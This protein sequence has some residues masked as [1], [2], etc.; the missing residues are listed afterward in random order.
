MV[1]IATLSDMVPL[2]GENRAL[3]HYGLAVL[4][5]S[6]RKGLVRLLSKLNI[7]QRYLS[8]DD[9][10]FM[11]T[12]RIN[13]M[14]RMGVP[15]DAFHMLSTEDENE[16]HSYVAHIEEI[17]NERKGMV[18]AL[19]KEVKKTIRER[20]GEQVPSVIVLGNPAWRPSLLGLAANSCAEEFD[21]PVFL[22]GRDGD[23]AIKGS[24]RSEGKTNVVNLMRAVPSGV[25]IHFGGH[26]H[27]GGFAVSNDA[28]HFLD[29]HLNEAKEMQNAKCKMQSDPA[30]SNLHGIN[31]SDEDESEKQMIDAELSL[32]MVDWR[33]QEELE[34]LAPFGTG[35]PKPVFLFRKV[36]PVSVRRFGKAKDHIEIMFKKANGNKLA[37]IAFF[38]AT[39]TWAEDLREGVSIDLVGSIEKSFF[40]GRRELR[41]RVVEVM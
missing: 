29:R 7:A 20:H 5:K 31:E 16:A 11:I 35:N 27:S 24:C 40:A 38:G 2:V 25:F 4:R 32:D 36:N 26:K 12:P 13:A 14:S 8:E 22:W 6:P 10:G 3:A 39:E 18:A 21:R 23:N 15:M 28:I 17:N 33:L 41:L 34:K 9:V 1:G 19:V 30:A 37:A